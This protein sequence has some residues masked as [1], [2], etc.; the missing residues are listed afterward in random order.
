MAQALGVVAAAVELLDAACLGSPVNHVTRRVRFL[1]L[2]ALQGNLEHP[3]PP[4]KKKK[5]KTYI[6]QKKLVGAKGY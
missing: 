3:P 2:V 4:P 1:G 6:K 5:K